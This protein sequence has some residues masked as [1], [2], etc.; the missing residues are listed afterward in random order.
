MT[1]KSDFTPFADW[2]HTTAEQDALIQR[3]NQIDVVSFDIFDTLL[4][5]AFFKPRDLFHYLELKSGVPHFYE[6]RTK[7]ARLTRQEKA[8]QGIEEI[9]LDEI[10]QTLGKLDDSLDATQLSALKILEQETEIA[11][12]QPNSDMFDFYQKIRSLNKR[13]VFTSDMYLPVQT[14]QKMLLKC[15][16]TQYDQLIV[17]NVDRLTKKSGRR[18]EHFLNLPP[19]KILHIGD[20]PVSDGFNAAKHG[21]QTILYQPALQPFISQ[22]LIKKLSQSKD[23]F[24]SFWRAQMTHQNMPDYWYSVGFQYIGPLLTHFCAFLKKNI[25]QKNIQKIAFMARDGQIM[26]QVFDILY[27][28]FIQTHYVFASRLMMQA[29]LGQSQK[30]YRD[31]LSSLHLTNGSVALVDVGRNGTL[32]KNLNTFF[33]NTS[34]IVQINGYYIDLRKENPTM[35]GYFTNQ[36]KK[37]KRF[38]DFLDFLMIAD[39]PLIMDIQKK[40]D[41]F[42][43]VYL[44]P[45]SDELTRENIARQMHAGAVDFARAMRPFLDLDGF[46]LSSKKL[47]ST[48]NCFMKFGSLDKNAFQNITIPFGLKNEKKRF[49]VAPHFSF[50]TWLK[51]PLHCLKIYRKSLIK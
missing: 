7:A 29:A 22:R 42:E 32:Q 2:P 9:S 26:K 14:L 11:L 15:G 45:D 12:C 18:F 38:L 16:Y 49:V 48:L 4:H 31:Y 1:S 47:L 23:L 20:N 39:H 33:E 8:K 27:P 28:D 40:N 50:K 25:E 19:S 46:Y 35:Y 36:P 44:T 24:S 41:F 21:I 13:I 5:R 6:N 17:S 3:L 37:Y 43:P 30:V 51:K 10:Y 34:E